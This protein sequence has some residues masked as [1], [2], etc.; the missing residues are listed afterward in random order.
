M[1]FSTAT[2]IA[3]IDS[4]NK[5]ATLTLPSVTEATGR[6]LYIKDSQGAFGTS[7]ITLSTITGQSFENN[8]NTFTLGDAGGYTMLAS[9]GV[10]KWY[11]M[12]GTSNREMSASNIK[13][14][15]INVRNSISTVQTITTRLTTRSTIDF[16]NQYLVGP[17]TSLYRGNQL[18]TPLTLNMTV[19]D[20]PISSL[21]S[22]DTWRVNALSTFTATSEFNLPFDFGAYPYQKDYYSTFTNKSLNLKT[23]AMNIKMWGVGGNAGSIGTEAPPIPVGGDAAYLNVQGFYPSYKFGEYYDPV[24]YTLYVPNADT[25]NLGVPVNVVS[26]G[27][28][29]FLDLC[30]YSGRGAIHGPVLRVLYQGSNYDVVSPASGGGGFW[31][32]NATSNITTRANG[33]SAGSNAVSSVTTVTWDPSLAN[34]SNA[35]GIG[36]G[37]GI[38]GADNRNNGGGAGISLNNIRKYCYPYNDSNY[39]N[40]S[41]RIVSARDA[42]SQN[43]PD[44]LLAGGGYGLGGAGNSILGTGLGSNAL[45]VIEQPYDRLNSNLTIVGTGTFTSLV[46]AP[47]TFRL[48]GPDGL[49]LALNGQPIIN[50]WSVSNQIHG[51]STVV[52]INDNRTY[53]VQVMAYNATTANNNLAFEYYVSESNIL[54]NFVQLAVSSGT[55]MNYASTSYVS[56]LTTGSLYTKEFKTESFIG[57][58]FQLVPPNTVTTTPFYVAS[59]ATFADTL[60]VGQ[61]MSVAKTIYAS[62]V[63]VSSIT[64]QNTFVSLESRAQKVE[65]YNS[66]LTVGAMEVLSQLNINRLVLGSTLVGLGTYGYLSTANVSATNF[67]STVQGLGSSGYLSSL[68]TVGLW[69]FISTTALQSTIDGLGSIGYVSTVMPVDLIVN[70]TVIGLGSSRYI[71]T[72]SLTSTIIGLGSAGYISTQNIGGTTL[73]ST[74][75]GLGTVGYISTVRNLGTLGYISSL[76]LTSTTSGLGSIG[77]LSTFIIPSSI[78]TGTTNINILLGSTLSL[79]VFTGEAMRI[80]STGRVGINTSTPFA[81]LDVSGNVYFRSTV[82]MSTGCL[83]INR[84]F[85][86]IPNADLDVNGIATMGALFVTSQGTF[87]TSVTAQTFATPS[88]RN[89]KSSIMTIS[90][91][92]ALIQK[93]RGVE[94]EWK[95]CG[96]RDYG[97]IAQE[98]EEYLPEAIF[99]ENSTMYVKYDMFVPIITEAL[100]G[101]QS[102][103]DDLRA[104]LKR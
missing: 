27:T 44:Y 77:Y 50:D 2:G 21:T 88:D 65:L 38:R 8:T 34:A 73:A 103:I 40:G 89:L 60:V 12:N 46:A 66:T 62:T 55:F 43:D 42:T 94:F 83:V 104:Q 32:F 79:N 57:Q 15:T 101:L 33:Q 16:N 36:G 53:S 102:Q 20:L 63:S 84:P 18:F 1:S 26:T 24:G 25:A 99:R 61:H 98:V 92:I 69:N 58:T 59:P 22:M 87:G 37:G 71:S 56:S 51:I 30:N 14:S 93:S 67:T 76:S 28:G 72:P 11:Q 75:T 23:R 74:V 78:S 95:D 6:Y 4:R 90:E 49:Y 81:N 3:L 91:P 45:A 52:N 5:S 31:Q 35:Y 41:V 96:K 47:V 82:Y 80:T 86:S 7:T 13:A 97:F 100:K 54:G 9:D 10:S 48:I 70:S 39:T 64:L 68:N 19:Y 85:N 17:S 29:V